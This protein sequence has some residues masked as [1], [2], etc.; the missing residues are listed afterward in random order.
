MFCLYVNH[1]SCQL[2][3]VKQKT[4]VIVL[5][6]KS[7]NCYVSTSH[8]NKLFKCTSHLHNDC[9]WAEMADSV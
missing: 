5:V 6:Y 2:T 7:R 8:S 1:C 3:A 4:K 9:K